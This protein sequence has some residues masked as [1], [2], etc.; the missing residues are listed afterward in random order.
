MSLPPSADAEKQIKSSSACF[1]FIPSKI[2]HEQIQSHSNPQSSFYC[3]KNT[4]QSSLP[5]SVRSLSR[6]GYSHAF[7]T[8]IPSMPSDMIDNVNVRNQL[9]FFF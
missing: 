4:Q 8:V 7:F 3:I 2:N 1:H 5:S 6:P 9:V